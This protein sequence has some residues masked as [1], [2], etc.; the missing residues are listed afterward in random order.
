MK[1]QN[2]ALL[3]VISLISAIILL[4]VLLSNG[5]T[6]VASPPMALST[7]EL[8]DKAFALAQVY[9]LQGSPMEEEYNYMPLAIWLIKNDQNMGS[10]LGSLTRASSIFVY[11]VKGD[12][13][14]RLHGYPQS[15]V[16]NPPQTYFVITLNP[17]DG[18]IITIS[19]YKNSPPSLSFTGVRDAGEPSV[20]P[21]IAPYE[22]GI[23]PD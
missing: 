19:H 13:K 22:P 9:G 2:L 8:R 10:T 16:I 21:T 23:D 6:S 18:K 5:A 12:I 4:I 15:A 11:K 7:T 1:L 3:T 20:I 14:P 17:S